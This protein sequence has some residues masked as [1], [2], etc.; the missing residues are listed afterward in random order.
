MVV[1][2]VS[3]VRFVALDHVEYVGRGRLRTLFSGDEIG[4][5]Y[6]S[7]VQHHSVSV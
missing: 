4:F 5:Y 7:A 2:A 3:S 6:H 1:A